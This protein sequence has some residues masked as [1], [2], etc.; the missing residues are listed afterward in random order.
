MGWI[1]IGAMA[2][3]IY[4]AW[5]ACQPTLP[6]RNINSKTFGTLNDPAIQ[7]MNKVSSKEYRKR[8]INGHYN[9]K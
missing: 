6:A 7:D 4:L 9:N 2:G 8:T 5:K 3:I 1:V